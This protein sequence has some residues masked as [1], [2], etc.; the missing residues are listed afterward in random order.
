[1]RRFTS[2]R[3]MLETRKQEEAKL[4]SAKKLIASQKYSDARNLAI[5]QMLAE[6]DGEV[7]Q[8][9]TNRNQTGVN[10]TYLD[11]NA[12][13]PQEHDSSSEDE[14]TPEKLKRQ[15]REAEAQLTANKKKGIS[16][17]LFKLS[18]GFNKL[19]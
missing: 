18:K 14:T 6:E 16:S 1:M 10:S 5:R 8:E 13:S 19:F 2:Q 12:D 17:K 7:S 15:I 4:Q 3:E 11:Y 9:A